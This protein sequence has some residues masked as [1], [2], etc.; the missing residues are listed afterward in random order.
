MSRRPYIR[1]IAACWLLGAAFYLGASAHS[2]DLNQQFQEALG[3]YHSGHF[4]DAS[5]KLEP[6][7]R[8]LPASFEAHELLGLSYAAQSRYDKA[9]EQL[10]FAIRIEPS[11]AT[12]RTNLATALLHS[13]RIEA[14]GDQFREAYALEPRDYTANHNLAEYYLQSKKLADAIPYLQT[15]H[16]LNP[17]AYDNSYD[18]ALGWFLTGRLAD[19]K[20]LVL[21]VLPQSDTS[22][23]HNL[24]GQIYEKDGQYLPAAAEFQTAARMEPSEENLFSWG[25]EL[26]LHRNYEAAIEIFR[27]AALQYPKS[28]RLRIGQGMALYAHGDYQASITVLLAAADADPRDAR[29]YLF[30]SKASLISPGQADEVIRRFRRYSELEPRN[31]LAQYFYAM[32]LWQ[33]K[34]AAP[35][36]ADMQKVKALLA[37]SITLDRNLADAQLQMGI[38]YADQHQYSNSLPFY[39]RALQL[40]P[41]L[42]DA[43]YRLGQYYVHTG[44]KAAAQK[45]FARSQELKSQRMAEVDKE[46]A[47]VQQFVLASKNT[48]TENP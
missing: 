6:V 41:N 37:K 38:L 19:A 42:A 22:E 2:Q 7:V 23:L 34:R 1:F 25:S 3:Q 45:E 5:A 26:L 48:S 40:D 21:S 36:G 32:S 18:L 44:D 35:A 11:S 17:S 9:V 39:E 12:G 8:S 43:H 24:L 14:A 30:L 29:C 28:A 13:G 31:A 33:E 4:A 10:Q 47:E 46:R 20:E 15:A 16:E 27:R